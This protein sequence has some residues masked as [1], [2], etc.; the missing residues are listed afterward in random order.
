MPPNYYSF[1][2]LKELTSFWSRYLWGCQTVR[3]PSHQETVPKQYNIRRSTD[4]SLSSQLTQLR[5]RIKAPQLHLS[6]W[7]SETSWTTMPSSKQ[8]PLDTKK[9]PLYRLAVDLSISMSSLL[10]LD[11]VP[12]FNN[13]CSTYTYL[14]GQAPYGGCSTSVW[15]LAAVAFLL[16]HTVIHASLV[17]IQQSH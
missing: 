3:Y 2:L 16:V 9:L 10:M 7:S 6:P 11:Q 8:L 17:S 4:L 1:R 15:K 14:L 12:F 13:W 5:T